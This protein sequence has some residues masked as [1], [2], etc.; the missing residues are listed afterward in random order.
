MSLHPQ[1]IPKLSREV[2]RIA[3]F[4]RTNGG[5]GWIDWQDPMELIFPHL[6]AEPKEAKTAPAATASLS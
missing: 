5:I 3:G 1:A 2:L 4:G 6:K